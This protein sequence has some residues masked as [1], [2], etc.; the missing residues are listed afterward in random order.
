MERRDFLEKLGI[1]AAF[2]LTSACLGSCKKDAVT[3]ADF[4]V[5]LNAAGNAALK[6]NGGYI[7]TNGVVVARTMGGE[8]VAATVTCSHEPRKQIIY[9]KNANEWVCTEHDARFDISGKGLN[10]KGSKGLTVYQ[11]SLTGTSL[12]IF[13]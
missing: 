8:Y 3:P 4:T 10:S 13:N 12:R 5:D 7:V 2:V 6:T 9:E 1:G 11:T